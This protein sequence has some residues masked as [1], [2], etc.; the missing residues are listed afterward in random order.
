MTVQVTLQGVAAP[1]LDFF[2]CDKTAEDLA[3]LVRSHGGCLGA[4]LKQLPETLDDP[5]KL[6]RRLHLERQV[7]SNFQ[8]T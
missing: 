3:N 2:K 6:E 1:D 8:S 7:Q 4:S 5:T